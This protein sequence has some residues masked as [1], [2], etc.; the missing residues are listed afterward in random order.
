MAKVAVL[1]SVAVTKL[2]EAEIFAETMPTQA[3]LLLLAFI[4]KHSNDGN[5]DTYNPPLTSKCILELLSILSFL[6]D[7]NTISFIKS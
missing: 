7:S 4:H 3:T 1:E 6:T 2:G 5:R